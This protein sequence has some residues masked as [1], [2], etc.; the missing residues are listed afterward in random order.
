MMKKVLV[1]G[2]GLVT[3]PLVRH[4]LNQPDF[5]VTVASRTVSK[6]EALVDGHPDGT[7]LTLLAGETDKLEKLISEHDLSISL[8]PAPLHPVVAELCIKHKKHMVTTS[9]VGPKMQELDGPAKQAGIMVLNEIGVD[10]GIDHMSAMRIIDDVRK[11]GGK[12]SSFKSYCGGL[13]APADNDNPWGYKFSWSP[14][15]VC[16]AGKNSACYRLNGER[17]D[18]PGPQLFTDNRHGMDIEGIGYLESYP[19]RDSL[20]YIDI[21]GLEGIDTMFRGTFRYPGWC[22]TLKKVVDLGLLE[23]TPAT[24][25]PGT[26]FAQFMGTFVKN[27]GSGDVRKDLAAQLGIEESSAIL[28]RFEWLG[29]FSDEEVGI[30]DRETTPLDILANRMELK[31]PYRKGERDMIVLCHDF[32]A[33]FPSGPDEHITSTLIDYGQVEGDSSMARTVS[34]PAAVG[35]KL[36]LAGKVMLPGVHVPVIPEIYNPVLDELATMDINCIEKTEKLG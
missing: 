24:Y 29:L 30:T 27:P 15:A 9:Y 20:G 35:A 26:T 23:E 10:P 7:T 33:K 6:A 12:V 4:L 22:E 36:I 13:P 19:N 34:L 21:Y 11:R 5:K 8:L 25:Q 1:L 14:R 28:D 18:I 17:V 16:T 32:F 31:M 2:A 3:R